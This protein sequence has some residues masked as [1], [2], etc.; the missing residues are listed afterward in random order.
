MFCPFA[1]AIHVPP[2]ASSIELSIFITQ[3]ICIRVMRWLSICSQRSGTLLRC[4][5]PPRFER[6]TADRC[7]PDANSQPVQL[8]LARVVFCL[9][10][11]LSVSLYAV[12][13]LN[14]F[15][16]LYQ[17]LQH[18]LSQMN[19]QWQ[20]RRACSSSPEPNHVVPLENA[21]SVTTVQLSIYL[22]PA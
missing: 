8:L 5:H 12:F 9:H 18:H 17:C 6:E 10:I 3:T 2:L 21:E 15:L 22:V 19:V 1:A 13:V 16:S 4:Y 14:T 11:T 20:R 7:S